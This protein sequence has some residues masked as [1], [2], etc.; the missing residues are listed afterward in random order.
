MRRFYDQ[1]RRDRPEGE[2][3]RAPGHNVEPPGARIRAVDEILTED[4]QLLAVG[5]V[6]CELQ[7]V[8][9]SQQLGA[10]FARPAIAD[11]QLERPDDAVS[12]VPIRPGIDVATFG[13]DRLGKDVHFCP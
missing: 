1:R 11:E 5:G 9:R 12:R 2:E 4:D 7:V 3:R 13:G 6:G 8:P 10:R